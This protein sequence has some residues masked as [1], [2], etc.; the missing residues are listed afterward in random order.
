MRANL[1]LVKPLSRL[2]EEQKAVDEIH[3]ASIGLSLVRGT[4][5]EMAGPAST[6]KTSV[7]V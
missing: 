7:A 6:G 3:L 5:S 1:S 4:V 2:Q